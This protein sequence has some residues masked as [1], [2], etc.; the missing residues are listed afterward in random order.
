MHTIG[1]YLFWYSVCFISDVDMTKVNLARQQLTTVPS[2]LPTAVTTLKLERNSLNLLNAGSFSNYPGL[3]I[4]DLSFNP[5]EIIEDGTFNH[6]ITLE[7]LNLRECQIRQLPASFGPSTTTIGIWDIHS[8]F[9]TM[10]IFQDPY[11]ADFTSL[12]YLMLGFDGKVISLDP[13]ILPSSMRFLD[14][15]GGIITTLPDFS[16]IPN[17]D[18]LF[19]YWLSM[20]HIPQ[21]HIDPLIYVKE[22]LLDNN[23]LTLMPNLSHMPLLYDLWIYDN[24][25]QEVPRSHISGLVSLKNLLMDRNLLHMMPNCSYLTKLEELSLTKNCIT[26]VPASTL[27]G[28][29]KLLKLRLNN[30]KISVLGDITSLWARLYLQNNNLTTLPDLYNMKLKTLM[31]KGNPLSCNQSLCWLRMWPWNKPLP[32]L[33]NVFCAT[34]SDMTEVQA[35]RVHP[36]KLQCFNGTAIMIKSVSIVGNSMPLFTY[37]YIYTY[38]LIFIYTYTYIYIHIYIHIY[39]YLHSQLHLPQEYHYIDVIITTMASQSPASRLFTQ[40]YIQTQIKENIKAPRHWPLCG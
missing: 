20:E 9:T 24:L 23:K 37:I 32:T 31:L 25:I 1:Q 18:K 38:T 5:L 3:R 19:L 4:L 17:L 14:I 2:D 21:Q 39:P 7:E 36:T 16:Y 34:P 33:D 35:V 6:Q 12:R 30:N 40:P 11:F 26:H 22:I 8:G 13:S 27:L 15:N 29:P 28:I 10:A